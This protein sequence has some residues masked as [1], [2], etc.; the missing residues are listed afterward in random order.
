MIAPL[1]VPH[2]YA[3]EKTNEV[4]A[5]IPANSNDGRNLQDEVKRGLV[6]GTFTNADILAAHKRQEEEIAQR[7]ALEARVFMTSE[8]R[9]KAD[10]EEEVMKEM[11]KNG[12]TPKCLEDSFNTC[13]RGV[14]LALFLATVGLGVIQIVKFMQ[15]EEIPSFENLQREGHILP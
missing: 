7:R 10:L 14:R 11:K 8:Q 15:N 2:H 4:K 1:P 3:D 5:A 6:S 9:K 13:L 12:L